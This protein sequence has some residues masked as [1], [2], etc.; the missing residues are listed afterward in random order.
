MENPEVRREEK[1]KALFLKG[2]GYPA[3]MARVQQNQDSAKG[4]EEN[5]S[6]RVLLK[7]KLFRHSLPPQL[8]PK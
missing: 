3:R 2:K 7:V 8:N 6:L 1:Y 4:A 5:Q